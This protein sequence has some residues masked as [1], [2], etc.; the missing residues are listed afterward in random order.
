MGIGDA[1]AAEGVAVAGQFGVDP[2]AAPAGRVPRFEDEEA[3][4]LAQ[5]EAVAG[6]VEGAAGTLGRLV[7]PVTGRPGDKM[8]QADRGDHGVEAPGQ[9]AVGGAAPI[10]FIAIPTAWLPTHRP[11]GPNWRS[12]ESRTGGAEAARAGLVAKERQV[13]R[14]DSVGQ[15]AIRVEVAV[16]AQRRCTLRARRNPTLLP[17]P[18]RTPSAIRRHS[19]AGCRHRA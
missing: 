5:D 19:P 14:P 6:G 17:L 11:C 13:I 10:S 8:R 2:R 1:I 15:Q 9:D 7:V 18:P 3:G 12:R 16:G 4:A